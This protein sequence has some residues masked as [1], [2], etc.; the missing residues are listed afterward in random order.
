MCGVASASKKARSAMTWKR[1]ARRRRRRGGLAPG[2][3][4]GAPPCAAPGVG[5]VHVDGAGG[6]FGGAV[7][8]AV[9][10]FVG[11]FAVQRGVVTAP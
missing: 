5:G 3:G 11:G 4:G 1:S 7:G 9:E 10:H 6:D 8:A 2:G